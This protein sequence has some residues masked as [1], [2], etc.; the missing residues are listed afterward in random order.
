MRPKNMGKHVYLLTLEPLSE[1]QIS[2]HY[3]NLA[4]NADTMRISQDFL[5]I[6]T[7]GK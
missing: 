6:K 5:C 2:C 7:C 4:N 1:I 3:L